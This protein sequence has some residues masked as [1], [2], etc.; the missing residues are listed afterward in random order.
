MP[1]GNLA[2]MGDLELEEFT[3]DEFNAE[4]ARILR[5]ARTM[6]SRI[7]RE[8]RLI[9]LN[10]FNEGHGVD[11]PQ[12][13]RG[14]FPEELLPTHSVIVASYNSALELD[15]P[16]ND[17][18]SLRIIL[19][20]THMVANRLLPLTPPSEDPALYVQ[21]LI[22]IIEA[23]EQ[24]DT[25]SR[26]GLAR[27]MI[28]RTRH[29][30][31]I[32]GALDLFWGP[33]H[34]TIWLVNAAEYPGLGAI[35]EPTLELPEYPLLGPPGQPSS[36]GEELP[37]FYRLLWFMST[38][39]V[40]HP[41]NLRREESELQRLAT[42]MEAGAL[43]E[44]REDFLYYAS[45]ITSDRQGLYAIRVVIAVVESLLV[46]LP[47][48]ARLPVRDAEL[49]A[50]VLEIINAQTEQV[51]AAKMAGARDLHLPSLGRV[52]LRQIALAIDNLAGARRFTTYQQ[53]VLTETRDNLVNNMPYPPI[54]PRPLNT[55]DT[56]AQQSP[57][58]VKQSTEGGRVY[59]PPDVDALRATPDE[60]ANLPRR[61]SDEDSDICTIC[62]D[63]KPRGGTFTY[64]PCGHYFHTD[65]INT[66]LRVCGI[67]PECR[68]AISDRIHGQNRR[69]WIWRIAL[70]Q[71]DP[72]RIGV[73]FN[74]GDV[75]RQGIRVSDMLREIHEELERAVEAEEAAS[76][77]IEPETPWLTRGPVIRGRTPPPGP[78][79]ERRSGDEQDP[80][81]QSGSGKRHAESESSERPSSTK[82]K[83]LKTSTS[84]QKSN[85]SQGSAGSKRSR[86]FNDNDPE[87]LE[88]Q[89]S[90][91]SK[92][93]TGSPK[94]KKFDTSY[95]PETRPSYSG[96]SGS[97]KTE[98]SETSRYSRDV[99]ETRASEG[100]KNLED[101]TG[102]PKD[103]DSDYESKKSKESKTSKGHSSKGND[104]N[105]GSNKS[106][107]SD[108]L[109]PPGD[110]EYGKDRAKEK[111]PSPQNKSQRSS[112]GQNSENSVWWKQFLQD[113]P[114]QDP[115]SQEPPP[116]DS[117][118]QDFPPQDSPPK[119]PSPIEPPPHDS[120]PK[121]PSPIDSPQDS[122][123]QDPLPQDSPKTPS[124]IDFPPIDPP[125]QD[126]PPNT[127]PPM[128]PPKSPSSH[129]SRSRSISPRRN[130][131]RDELGGL[132]Q[133][134][135]HPGG[136]HRGP[137]ATVR[138]IFRTTRNSIRRHA[139]RRRR[140]NHTENP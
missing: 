134:R 128:Y 93:S 107:Q 138:D 83:R 95:F 84:S 50:V 14:S 20:L 137:L 24:A 113:T 111:G 133:R 79:S 37:I 60:L 26:A 76:L 101:S 103:E 100:S 109:V 47:G 125:P 89:G 67:C 92:E 82:S 129:R 75:E 91:K 23:R 116:Q 123:P 132:F 80:L 42:P 139:R 6:Y 135:I 27:E 69:T 53:L 90:K 11:D 126:S 25:L 108:G 43:D 5:E 9:R 39:L 57:S 38:V 117:P 74:V 33:L 130:R 71:Q 48:H 131:L 65:C 46:N 16:P 140:R 63:D 68:T 104:S 66:W 30:F 102:F 17:R 18:E 40:N 51:T 87:D 88:S 13:L 99:W 98:A 110:S 49:S 70:M 3:P 15:P 4:T 119:T 28:N 115:P 12:L 77:E 122:P 136:R 62:A 64:L 44:I 124:P 86:E 97:I 32:E 96:R 61:I 59:F 85:D 1:P 114:L 81:E 54:T 35:P 72:P 56:D 8:I 21:P 55:N 127:P 121:T 112:K 7:Y 19:G 41:A 73:G 10:W 105:H 2:E 29:L 34:E 120:R 52:S 78:S 94:E 22:R 36:P 106:Q 58:N 118:R 31:T 45:Q